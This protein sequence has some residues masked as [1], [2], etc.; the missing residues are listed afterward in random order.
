MKNSR[1]SIC[2][3]EIPRQLMQ[4]EDQCPDRICKS[5]VMH[6]FA[7]FSFALKIFFL[8]NNVAGLFVA[9]TPRL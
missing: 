5:Y 3:G 8:R 2:V 6:K 7:L 1:P 4:N 9:A